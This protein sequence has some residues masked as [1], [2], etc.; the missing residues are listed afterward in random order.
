MSSPI[1]PTPVIRRFDCPRVTPLCTKA[2]FTFMICK[3]LIIKRET[4]K[5]KWLCF[6]YQHDDDTYHTT[7]SK[8]FQLKQITFQDFINA[9]ESKHYKNWEDGTYKIFIGST[10][11]GECGIVEMVNG[12]IVKLTPYQ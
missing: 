10:S 11:W 4:T 5:R 3:Q 9:C 12:K 7:H 1:A 2:K 8:K 6:S